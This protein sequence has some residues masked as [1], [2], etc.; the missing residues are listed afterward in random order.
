MEGHRVEERRGELADVPVA[1]VDVAEERPSLGVRDPLGLVDGRGEFER[2]DPA[3]DLGSEVGVRDVGVE[4][5]RAEPVEEPDLL[6]RAPGHG[7]VVLAERPFRP[8]ED[9]REAGVEH[10]D[11]LVGRV[12]ERLGEERDEDGVAPLRPHPLEGLVRV[13]PAEPGEHLEPVGGERREVPAVDAP[14]AEPREL[15]GHVEERLGRVRR[16]RTPEPRECRLAAVRAAAR[17][18][19]GVQC[20]LRLFR[21]GQA[22]ERLV[23]GL[24]SG[25]G[26]GPLN[27]GDAGAEDPLALELLRRR[28]EEERGPVVLERALDEPDGEPVEVVGRGPAEPGVRRRQHEVLADGLRAVPVAREDVRGRVDL[29]GEV[30]HGLGRRP[31]EVGW[32]EAEEPEG[33]ELEREP[34]PIAVAVESADGPEVSVGEREVRGDVLARDDAGEAAE[35]VALGRG[36]ESDGHESS[37]LSKRVLGVRGVHP[38]F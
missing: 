21:E 8:G 31:V 29:I 35:P 20:G 18:E 3:E 28:L 13:P 1:R 38:P 30:A 34:E 6:L 25:R 16:G 14:L 22:A 7:L 27:D 4:H 12:D 19:E 5:E 36:E 11:R 9:A 33:R 2:R 32:D 37:W 17:Y 26:H 24:G 23:V 10:V 15:R